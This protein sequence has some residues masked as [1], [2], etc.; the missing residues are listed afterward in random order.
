MRR[1]PG[2]QPEIRASMRRLTETEP[3]VV[4]LNELLTMHF[5]PQDVLVALSPDF[6]SARQFI[7][8][9]G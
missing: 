9:S 6:V 8:P 1:W 2:V 5:G 4:R 3:G 7:A